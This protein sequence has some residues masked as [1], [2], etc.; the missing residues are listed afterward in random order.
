MSFHTEHQCKHESGRR[1]FRQAASAWC[2]ATGLCTKSRR[3]DPLPPRCAPGGSPPLRGENKAAHFVGSFSPS[4][5]GR[6]ERSERG[7]RFGD[8]L[9]KA[10]ANQPVT[11]P[12][13]FCRRTLSREG[14]GVGDAYCRAGNTSLATRSILA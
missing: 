3:T 6:R 5:R 8:F 12:E 13:R 10:L 9:C 14:E 11:K 7:G 4:Q 1:H 2:G